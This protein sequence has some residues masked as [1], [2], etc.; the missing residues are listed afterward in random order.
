MGL[1]KKENCFIF[2]TL[3]KQSLAITVDIISI[4][5]FTV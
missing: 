4:L 2:K 5:K 1:Q 3:N